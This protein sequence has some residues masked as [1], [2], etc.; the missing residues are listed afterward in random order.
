MTTKATMERHG[1]PAQ[2]PAADPGTPSA[3]VVADAEVLEDPPAPDGMISVPEERRAGTPDSGTVP[4]G[5]S[6]RYPK[7]TCRNEA[8]RRAVHSYPAGRS[9]GA[10]LGKF[11]T[12]SSSVPDATNE[13][14]TTKAITAKVVAGPSGPRGHVLL[15]DEQ[16]ND[17]RAHRLHGG[18]RWQRVPER[19]ETIGAVE[20]DV[21]E[22]GCAEVSEDAREHEHGHASG[23]PHGGCVLQECSIEREQDPGPD[24]EHRRLDRSGSPSGRPAPGAQRSALS[25]QR[26]A[27]P[28]VV[29]HVVAC[30][31]GT[32]GGLFVEDDTDGITAVCHDTDL[33]LELTSDHRDS[34]VSG[35]QVLL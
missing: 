32:E 30:F 7:P 4:S 3:A 29:E 14:T 18:E 8:R 15:E 19:C 10:D 13:P 31:D 1:T 11:A 28:N 24:R 22:H 26:S 35:C 25:A 34:S 9:E 20:Q 21:S 12:S 23:G 2:P 6:S 5:I 16:C 17:E 33:L 27:I